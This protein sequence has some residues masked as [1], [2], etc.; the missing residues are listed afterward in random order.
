MK[1]IAVLLLAV[2]LLCSCAS[3]LAANPPLPP[4]DSFS[5]MTTL[6]K[7][8]V[9]YITLSKPVDKLY[10]NWPSELH[11]AELGVTE[12]LTSAAYIGGQT[13]QPGVAKHVE[14]LNAC[15]SQRLAGTSQDRAF[16]AW[17]GEWLVCYN[18]EGDIIAVAYAGETFDIQKVRDVAFQDTGTSVFDGYGILKPIKQGIGN[19]TFYKRVIVPAAT[20]CE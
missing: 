3:A 11:I 7:N 8:N 4:L 19:Y 20:K 10:I 14:L 13:S 5:S 17:E 6:T 9:I 12:N 16:I 2:M 15:P 1:K 18:R